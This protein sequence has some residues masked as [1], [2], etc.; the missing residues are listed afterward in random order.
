LELNENQEKLLSVLYN[1]DRVIKTSD[2]HEEL[3]QLEADVQNL[4]DQLESHDTE[5]EDASKRKY[6]C[7]DETELFNKIMSRVYHEEQLELPESLK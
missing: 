7:K 5:S 2:D 6:K 3:D 1:F 4:R